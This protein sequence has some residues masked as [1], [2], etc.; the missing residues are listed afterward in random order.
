M[1]RFMATLGTAI[2]LVVSGVSI[3]RAADGDDV[4]KA[5]RQVLDDQQTAW[6]KGDLEGFMA[7]YWKSDD[8]SFYSGGDKTKGWNATYERYKKKYQ[9][10]G[11]EMGTLAFSELDISV[12][13]TDNA[14]VRGRWQLKMKDGKSMGGL[15]TLWV[16]KLPEG[17]RIVHDHTSKAD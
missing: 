15:Y 1:I 6:N 7:G 13:G 8:L 5:I 3:V 9:S 10:D 17:W 11:N 4:K 12:A 2:Y 16:R 14:I